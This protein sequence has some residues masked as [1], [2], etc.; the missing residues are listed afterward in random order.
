VVKYSPGRAGKKITVEQS[1]VGANTAESRG[2]GRRVTLW[3]IFAK[4]RF[5]ISSRRIIR[6]NA[7]QRNE[8]TIGVTHHGTA[9]FTPNRTCAQQRPSLECW[10]VA[11]SRGRDHETKKNRKRMELLKMKSVAT[12][13]GSPWF[14]ANISLLSSSP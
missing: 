12:T 7:T 14:E 13:S 2:G 1:H 11:T 8:F 3:S 4:K 10:Q 9:N 6:Q 5:Q